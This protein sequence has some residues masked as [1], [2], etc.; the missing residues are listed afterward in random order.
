MIRIDDPALPTTAAHDLR[1]EVER[2]ST[3]LRRRRRTGGAALTGAAVATVVAL[4]AVTSGGDSPSTTR[5]GADRTTVPD[6]VDPEPASP[7]PADPGGAPGKQPSGGSRRPN[8]TEAPRAGAGAVP[9]TPTVPSFSKGPAKDPSASPLP[10]ARVKV[11]VSR[12]DGLF[13]ISPDGSSRKIRTSNGGIR[14]SPDGRYL[15]L[16]ADESLDVYDLQTDTTRTVFNGSSGDRAGDGAAWMP[17]SRTAVFVRRIAEGVIDNR[18]ELWTVDVVTGALRHVRNLENAADNPL[19][20]SADGV[21]VY[22]CKTNNNHR[23]CLTNGS[24][25][26]LGE[27]PNSWGA[28]DFEISPDGRWIAHAIPEGSRTALTIIRT[29]GSLQRRLV[30][31]RADTSARPGWTADS[32]RVVFGLMWADHNPPPCSGAPPCPSDGGVWS[33]RIDGT[34]A[35]PL[36]GTQNKDTLEGVVAVP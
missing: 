16:Q 11:L 22:R 12:L 36:A 1:A 18:A 23:L 30:H 21:I 19:S 3:G 32:S 13:E 9:T 7:S 33:I 35:R 34:D 29:D 24:G 27:V 26:E 8:T 25:A 20:V 6:S 4:L 17:D 5:V 14:W 10:D 28:L 15:L 2:R 31:D